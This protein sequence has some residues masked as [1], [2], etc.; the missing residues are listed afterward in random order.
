MNS[1]LPIF[2]APALK[3]VGVL[4]WIAA[5]VVAYGGFAQS[6]PQTHR[7]R[8]DQIQF[9]PAVIHAKVGDWIVFKNEDIV[10][11][12]ASSRPNSGLKFESGTLQNGQS[13]SVRL[14]S[15]GKFSYYCRFHL[16]MKG[17]IEVSQ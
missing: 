12:T 1:F 2:K 13:F 6:Q 16:M 5:P 7:V 4:F 17:E 14:K 10:P 11:H 8:I 15:K 3:R 9:Q